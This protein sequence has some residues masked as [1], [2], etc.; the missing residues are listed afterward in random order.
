MKLDNASIILFDGNCGFCS[1]SVL[2]IIKHDKK[3]IFKF[4]SLQSEFGKLMLDKFSL[5][6][7]TESVVLIKNGAA[8]QKSAAALKVAK[9]FTWPL[10]L[11]Y[12]FIIIP[13]FIRDFIYDIIAKNRH[14][15]LPKKQV[16]DLHNT[17]YSSRFINV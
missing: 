14:Y 5:E 4:A 8:F 1:K 16:C 9:E 11:L 10:K 17:K 15:I 2:F 6:K 12:T 3:G 7:N 13:P